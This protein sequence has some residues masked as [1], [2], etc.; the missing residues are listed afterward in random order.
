MINLAKLII[1]ITKSESKIVHKPAL[2]KGD[3]RRRKP[4]NS[5][6]RELMPGDLISLEDGINRYIAEL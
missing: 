3:M 4:D 2:E 6:M 1:N 5:L